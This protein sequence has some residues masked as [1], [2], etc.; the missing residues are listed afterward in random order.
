MTLP[1]IGQ[2]HLQRIDALPAKEKVLFYEICTEMFDVGSKF[3]NQPRS[4]ER[5]MD[6]ADDLII[7]LVGELATAIIHSLSTHIPM[8]EDDGDEIAKVLIPYHIE[9]ESLGRAGQELSRLLYLTMNHMDAK[10]A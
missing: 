2:S 6:L 9:N 10:A 5:V 7:N 4:T 1:V 3:H 8:T